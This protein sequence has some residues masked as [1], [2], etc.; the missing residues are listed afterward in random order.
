MNPVF[1]YIVWSTIAVAAVMSSLF[2]LRLLI[3][4]GPL[5]QRLEAVAQ[6]LEA[7]RPRYVQIL[8]DLEAQVSELRGISESVHHMARTAEDFTDTMR[9][10]AQPIV[11]EVQDLSR[12]ARR[13]HVVLAAARSGLAAFIHY[14]R[15]ALRVPESSVASHQES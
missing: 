5:I 9:T 15:D 6:W 4:L 14:R 2:L 12:I 10:A 3:G 11:D 13:A 8:E 7:G 1:M